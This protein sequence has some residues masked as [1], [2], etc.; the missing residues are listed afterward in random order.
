MG[1]LLLE[2]RCMAQTGRR[3]AALD[4]DRRLLLI[5]RLQGSRLPLVPDVL[6]LFRYLGIL[7]LHE[8]ARE[9]TA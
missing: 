6:R 3:L 9:E 7:A 1:L 8:G 2:I 4:E 5:E